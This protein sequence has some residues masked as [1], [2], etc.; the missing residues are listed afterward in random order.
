MTAQDPGAST[1]NTISGGNQYGPVMQGRD[2]AVTIQSAVA[3]PVAL[4]QLPPQAA[5]FSGRNDELA[6]IIELLDPAANGGAVVV[7][8]AGLAGVG[9]TALAIAAG[10][11]ALKRGWFSGGVLF[12]DLHGYDAS[13]VGPGQALDSLLRGLGVP[14]EHIPPEAAER[15]GLYRSTLAQFGGPVL[16]VADNASSEAQVRPLLPGTGPHRVVVTSRHTLA[17]LDAR[18]LDITVLNAE[19]SVRLLDTLVRAARP[20]DGRIIGDPSAAARLADA[21]GGLP[22]ALQIVAALLK[23]DPGLAAA[24]LATSLESEQQRLE[25]LRYDEGDAGAVLSVEAAFELSYRGLAPESARVFRLLPLIPGPD[26][27]TASVAVLADLPPAQARRLLADLARAHL[28][29]EVPTGSGRWQ[30]H[31]LVR[32]Y[33]QRL[34]EQ[35]SAAESYREGLDRLFGYYLRMTDAADDHLRALPGTRVPDDFTGRSD[36]LAWLDA[37]RPSLVA[38][39]TAACERGRDDIAIRLPILLAEYLLWRR[40]FD[41]LITSCQL[42]RQRRGSVATKRVRRAALTYLGLALQEVRR[43]DEAITAHQDAAAIYRETSDRHREGTALNNL[44]NTLHEVRRFDEA[45]TAHQDAAAIYRET[46]DRHRE[47][48][49]LN[50]LGL[51]L[52]QVRRFDEAITAH[53]QDLAI[54]R[55]IGDRHGEGMTLSNLGSALHQVRRFDEAI[56]AHQDAAAICRETGDRHREGMALNNLGL[57]LRGA[58]RFDEAITAH[59]DAA[60]IYRE[61]SDRHGEGMTLGNLGLALYDVRRF[62]EA[63]TA[64]EDAAAIY[65]ETSDRH[66]EG[67][68]LGNLGSALQEVRR[69]DEAITAHQDAAAIYRET[70]DRHGEGTALNNLGLALQEVRRLDEAITA[71]QDAIEIFRETGDHHNAGVAQRNLEDDRAEQRKVAETAA[72]VNTERGQPGQ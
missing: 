36:A 59:Q 72:Q 48:M 49:A 71:H 52:R 30:M 28:A 3:A 25:Q 62:D 70:S 42:S 27:S 29:D 54:C 57:A 44:G 11:E 7:S 14:A 21:C 53:Q 35:D 10:H 47:G 61:T 32:L 67:T 40:R 13:A 8:A 66:G 50:N 12:I 38:T 43:F 4:A 5:G 19:A 41:D 17:N 64:H 58:R 31:D 37:E 24:D 39:I 6:Q 22:L 68:A 20:E 60:A 23:A 1:S 33:A 51:A 56:T 18:L 9:K 34:A 69:H 2:F 65:R 16:I 45:I 46:G 15:A 63:I 55:E 26:A